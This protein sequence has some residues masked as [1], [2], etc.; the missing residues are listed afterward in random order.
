MIK[1]VF[2][3][4]ATGCIGHYIM[5]RLLKH[6]LE[7]H[8]LVRDQNRL[9]IK[10]SPSCS[11]MFHQGNIEHI[12]HHFELLK[13][14]DAI[15]HIATDWS[16]SEYANQLN[17]I[18]THKMFDVACNE[19]KCERIIYFSTASILGPNNTPTR[20]AETKGSGYVRSK[21]LAYKALKESPL[22]DKV[23]TLFPT[24]V[25]GGDLNLPQSH[26]TSGIMPNRHY[27]KLLR[28]LNVDASCHFLH[29]ED[30][31]RVTEYLMFNTP[32]K[33]DYVLGNAVLTLNRIIDELCKCFHIKHWIKIPVNGRAI[34]TLARWLNI[35]IDPWTDH[36]IRHPH[37]KYETVSPTSFG[38][39]TKYPDIETVLKEIVEMH[40]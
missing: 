26:I 4:G 29:A 3:T 38:L 36:C 13:E 33:N 39:Q 22:Q 6:D 16:N 30:I 40:G 19:G 20:A 17:N 14:M 9:K 35:E 5:Q 28:F 1:K 31:A 10:P 34:L 2:I 7:C 27:L 11:F 15:I 37:M 18:N 25:V 21:Y 23:I 24:L 32:D 8:L 12:H